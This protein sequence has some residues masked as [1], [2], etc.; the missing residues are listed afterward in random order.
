M[1][2]SDTLPSYAVAPTAS[3]SH[4]EVASDADVSSLALLFPSVQY[5]LLSTDFTLKMA[6]GHKVREYQRELAQP[7]VEGK[8]YIIIAPTGSEKT[9]VAALVIS[10]HLQKNQ[11]HQSCHV[12]FVVNTKPLAEQQKRQL[13]SIIPGARVEV[14]TG[15]NPGK[16]R[17]SIQQGN[18]IS[19]CTAGKLLDEIRKGRVTFDQ[20]SLMVFDE[21]HHTR[22]GHPYARLMEHY[23]EYKEKQKRLI[24]PQIIGMTASLG[25]GGNYD[26]DKKKTIDH[27]LK[28]AAILDADGGFQTVTKNLAELQRTT[29]NSSCTQKI[30]KPRNMSG[31]PFVECIAEEMA[32]LE[33]SVPKMKNHFER[34]SQEYKARVHKVKQPLELGCDRRVRDTISTLNLLRCYSNVLRVYMDLQQHDAITE[35]EN[36]RGFPEDEKATPHEYDAKQ[37]MTVLVSELKML[38]PSENPL[39]EIM[40]ATL[41]D[42]FQEKPASQAILFIRT[43]NHAYSMRNWVRE[44]PKLQALKPDVITGHTRETGSG[45]TQV[46]Q[47]KVMDRFR[48][49]QTNLLIATSVAEEGLDVPECNVVIEFRHVS[50]EIAQVQTEG[51]ARAENSQGVMI[52]SSDSRKKYRELMSVLVEEILE[53]NGFPAHQQLKD[54]LNEIQQ[55]IIA[56]RRMKAKMVKAHTDHSTVKL[57]CKKCKVLACSG[58]DIYIFGKKGSHHYVVPESKF[59][60]KI[61]CSDHPSP[62]I[63]DLVSREVRNINK[64]YCVECGQS[65]GVMCTWVSIGR[66][67][68]VIKCSAFTFEIAGVTRTIKKWK[69]APFNMMHLSVFLTDLVDDSGSCSSA[70]TGYCDSQS[71]DVSSD[72]DY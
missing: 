40:M 21:C 34:W 45:M 58:R 22:K 60:E 3:S 18:N 49:G 4:V 47:E 65:W 26:L 33:E 66:N 8:N 2:L 54:R 25:A 56:H 10:N 7:G 6:D 23:L 69:D 53:G 14:Y 5:E 28:L 37:R 20:F 30:F 48:K 32:K 38:Q 46:E 63:R 39:L 52:L 9:V 27:L 51:R 70:D 62:H 57:F 41:L 13:D 29:K 19:V 71:S 68:P 36:Y 24:L 61:R 44:H 11:L 72:S 17:D 15:D 1:L 50:N 31:D 55:D 43:K 12:V 42:T 35:L 67:F 16:I 64:I 59:K